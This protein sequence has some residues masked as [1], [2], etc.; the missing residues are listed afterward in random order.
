[1]T[2]AAL[3]LALAWGFWLLRKLQ[4]AQRELARR[5]AAWERYHERRT[6]GGQ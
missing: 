5:D 3:L 1:M 6:G 2:L 4:V